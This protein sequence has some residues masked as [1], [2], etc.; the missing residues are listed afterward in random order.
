MMAR[1]FLLYLIANYLV[2]LKITALNPIGRIRRTRRTLI[3][4]IGYLK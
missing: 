4:N 1:L 2:K 3:T